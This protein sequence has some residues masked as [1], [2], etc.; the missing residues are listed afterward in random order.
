MMMT[1]LQVTIAYNKDPRPIKLNLGEGKT[2]GLNVVR[3]AE[4]LLVNESPVILGNLVTRFSVSGQTLLPSNFICTIPGHFIIILMPIFSLV[5]RTIYI[6]NP[7]WG[8]HG[9]IFTFVG[10][11]VKTY[12]YYLHSVDTGTGL[13]YGDDTGT[14]NVKN[15]RYGYSKKK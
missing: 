6:P 7:S 12:C 15:T 1:D 9:K 8:N 14:G 5:K 4:K 2:L 10:L 11:T 13:G 3:Q